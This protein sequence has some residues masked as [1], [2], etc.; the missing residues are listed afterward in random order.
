MADRREQQIRF[1]HADE[2]QQL[3]LPAPYFV[4][5]FVLRW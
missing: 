4:D 1:N 2:Q 3:C 5:D